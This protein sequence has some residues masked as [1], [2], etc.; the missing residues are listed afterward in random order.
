MPPFFL[1]FPLI[2]HCARIAVRVEPRMGRPPLG[3]LVARTAVRVA[4]SAVAPLTLT[5]SPQLQSPAT[6]R[7]GGARAK[8]ARNLT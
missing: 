7:L 6:S 1:I 2:A 3:P 4:P 8:G 5:E